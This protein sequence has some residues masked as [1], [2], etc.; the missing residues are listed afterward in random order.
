MLDKVSYWLDL[1]DDD[2]SAAKLL[3]NG[4]MYLHV[5]FF[6]HIIAEKALKAMVAYTTSE[7]PPRSHDLVT[8]S[9]L[10]GLLDELSVKQRDLLVE[11]NP[12]NIEARYPEYKERIQKTLTTERT[13][14]I[15]QETEDLLCWIK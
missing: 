2:L 5:G 4:R 8:L 6:C 14:R 3:L 1:A 13:A 15:L 9:E 11:L 12:L 7:I 10:A